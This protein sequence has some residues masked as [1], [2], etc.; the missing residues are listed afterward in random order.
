MWNTKRDIKN[1]LK[2][3]KSSPGRCLGLIAVSALRTVVRSR[4]PNGARKLADGLGHRDRPDGSAAVGVV[5]VGPDHAQA[6]PTSGLSKVV[7]GPN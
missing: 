3:L 4:L 2:Y 1:I 5:V 7:R 6:T